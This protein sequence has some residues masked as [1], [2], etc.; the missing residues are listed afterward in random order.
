MP[1]EYQQ[2]GEVAFGGFASYPNPTSLDPQK[3]VL[4]AINNMRITEGVMTPRAGSTLAVSTGFTAVDYAAS[5][6]T[7]SGDFIYVWRQGVVKRYCTTTPAG[8]VTDSGSTRPYRPI[9]GQGY[10]GL[11]TIEASGAANWTGEYDF[12]ACTNV[13]GRLAYAKNDQVWLTLFGG[14]Q[15]YNGD[16]IS[17]V[18]GT[19]DSIKALHYS[20]QSRKLYA[21]GNRSAYELTFGLPS[22]SLEAGKPTADFFHKVNL[23]T[24]QEGILAKDSVAEVAGSIFYLGHDGIYQIDAQKGMVEGQGPMSYPIDDVLKSA[25]AAEMQKAV[26][27]S[28]MGR[29]YLLLPNSTDYKRDRVLVINPRIP[30]VFESIDTYNFDMVSIMTARDANGVLSLWGVTADGRIINLE[31]G[32]SDLGY[33]YQSSFKTR[34]YNFRTDFDKRYDA[35]TLSL[36]TKGPANIEFYQNTVNPDSRLLIDQFNGNVGQA[37]RR[38]LAGKKCTGLV[39]EVV[40]KSGKP[41]FYSCTVD[42][43]ISGRSIFNVF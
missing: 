24:G 15:P 41:L 16:T 28:W 43:S 9:R 13:L 18:Q 1:R 35:C 6:S 38:A 23:L 39:L 3:G 30:N 27:V 31:S 36:D 20:N 32:S 8:M 33:Q 10:Q 19:Y 25:P 12:T 21:F 7:S 2:D 17:L 34:N 4:T 26:G 29:Y 11:A 22:M 14:L 37:V 5:A 42:G 40:V